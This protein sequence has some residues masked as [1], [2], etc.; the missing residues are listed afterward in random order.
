MSS[1]FP[2]QVST[3][4]SR[5]VP[6]LTTGYS[7][8]EAVTVGSSPEGACDGCQVGWNHWRSNKRETLLL[9]SSSVA[10]WSP[11]AQSGQHHSAD[12]KMLERL[13]SACSRKQSL[14]Q[15]FGIIEERI[16]SS[17]PKKDHEE[18]KDFEKQLKVAEQ[19]QRVNT[20]LT[21]S[22]AFKSFI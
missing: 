13:R 14:N 1:F 8:K 2:L 19:Q 17:E 20:L 7:A 4:L 16:L 10:W 12:E 9:P 18:F 6:R 22:F 15:G 5:M 11:W 21:T 3:S